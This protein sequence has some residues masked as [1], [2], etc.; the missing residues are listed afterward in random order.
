MLIIHSV[1]RFWSDVLLIPAYASALSISILF[2]QCITKLVKKRRLKS[3]LQEPLANGNT[4]SPEA[5]L[6]RKS[7]LRKHI[8]ELGGLAIFGWRLARLLACVA[9]LA[10]SVYTVRL[11][12]QQDSGASESKYYQWFQIGLSAVYAYTLL[13]ALGSVL[14]NASLSR[15]VVRHLALVLV[16]VWAVFC[17]RDLW[18]LA[19]YTLKPLDA[20]EGWLIWTKIGLLTFA[21]AAVPLLVPRQY[22]PVDPSDPA[23]QPNV[24]QTACI[25]SMMLYNF[26]DPVIFLGYRTPH[27]S[28]EQLPPLS[29]Y[30]Y[31]KNVVKRGFPNLDPFVTKS[32]RHLFFGLMKTFRSEYMILSLMIVL[33]VIS[34]FAVP[35]GIYRLLNYLTDEGGEDIVR[36]WVWIAWL[37]LGPVLGAI[38]VQWY[39]FV[40]TRMLVQSQALITQ[41]VFNHALRVRVKA[42]A[43]TSPTP[44]TASSV[45]TTPDTDSVTGE[46]DSPDSSSSDSEDETAASETTSTTRV[47]RGLSSHPESVSGD[48]DTAESTGGGNFVGKLNNLITTDLNNLTDGRDFLF[49]VLYI[50]FQVGLCVWFLYAILG[51]SALVGMVVII[52]MFPLP[53]YIAKVIQNVQVERMKKT[54]ARVQTVT[55]IMN[56]IRMIKIFGW[57]PKILEQLAEKREAELKFLRQFKLLDLSNGLLNFTIPVLTMIF[58]FMTY[59]LVMKQELTASRVFS[60]MSPKFLCDR[61]NDF[62]LNTELLDKYQAEVNDKSSAARE[63]VA[64]QDVDPSVIGIREAAFTWSSEAD[65]AQSPGEHHRNFTLRIDNEV[66]FKN[67]ALNL[68]VGP[69]GSGKTSFLMA[70]L[71][72]MHYLPSGPNSYVQLPRDGGVAYAAQESWVQN[73]TI[74]DNILFGAP[75]DQERYDKVIDQCGLKRDLELFE[76]GDKTEVGEKGLTLS[77]GQKARITL[78]RAIYSSAKILLLDDVLAA[79][80]VHTAKWVVDKCFKGD[81]IQGRTVLLVTHNVHMVKPIAEFVVS[82]G[83]D[84]KI[85]SQGSLSKALS[86]NKKLAQ[87]VKRVAEAHKAQLAQTQLEQTT[88]RTKKSDGK[89]IVAEE[90]SVGHVGWPAL[91]LYFA[92]LGGKMPISFWVLFLGGMLLTSITETYQAWYL[93]HWADQYETHDPSEVNVVYYIIVYTLLLLVLLISYLVACFVFVYGCLR[94]SRA[95]HAHLVSSVLGTT[96]RWLDRTPTSRIITRCTQDIQ[97]VDG[98]I[99]MYLGYLAEM[100]SSMLLKFIGVIVISPQFIIPGIIVSILGGWCGQIY[101]KSQLAVKRE[102][103][104]NRAPVLGHVGAAMGGLASIRAYGAEQAFTLESY[105]RIDRYS[106]PARTFYN[107]NRWVCIR[108]ETLA[109]LF[110]ASLGAYLVYWGG[111]S[112]SNTGF[113]LTMAVGFS[114]MI[115]W[116]I[117]LLNDFEVSG[118]SLERIQQYVVIEQEPKPTKHGVPPAYWPTSGELIVENLSAK[119][120][121]EGANVLQDVSFHVK[122]GERVGIVGR[123]GSGKSSLSLALLRCILTQGMILYDGM[124]T[125]TLNLD[126]LRSNITIIPQ[127][128]ELL[129]GTL[130]QNLDPFSQH[131][132]ATLNDALHA[133]G[134]YSLQSETDDTRLTLDSPIASGGG[135][136]SVG[137]RQILALARAIV[138]RSKLLILDEDYETD[139]IIQTSLRQQLDKDVTLLTIA[140]RLQTIMDADKIMV[141]DAGRLVEFDKPSELL[142]KENG[143]LRALVDE[144]EDRDRLM[145]M[146]TGAA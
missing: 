62:L 3:T 105:R 14:C 59:T 117:R 37:L 6:S 11:G 8:D 2:L 82:L 16:T 1:I 54:D 106:R 118:N 144:S 66:K 90:I 34:T 36:P 33:R 115:L 39:I 108:I 18:P 55:E 69:T 50:P 92:N 53:G 129:S 127:V 13:L 38:A 74:R 63:V 19:T 114:G 48:Q 137:Q 30:D 121:A 143:M 32:R 140:H 138:R 113:S 134:L 72:E 20:A 109:G 71:G 15:I 87:K 22:I 26:L 29:D 126:A 47:S 73:E 10:L 43:T 60:S 41:L 4:S 49:V 122:A 76:A 61:V 111:V 110:A 101:M 46:S 125:D 23:P 135:N 52:L 83:T 89:L 84:G 24:E 70:L 81:L 7:S 145:A 146:A 97:A 96:L 88:T 128:P 107:L 116:W 40:A 98:P 93:G 5:Q 99:A 12:P 136:L 123:T 119:Y 56:V 86:K 35:I 102:M 132:D 65:G 139:T 78:A 51:W 64:G 142:K 103:S 124:P 120:S 67:G 31:T 58:T 27:L 85:K 79:L 112:A 68:I 131:D 80:D 75:F 94:A 42:E 133:A 95:I 28:W 130:R 100:T 141:L 44:S 104:N 57:E 17:Y 77:G 91:K 21:G 9:L 45:A 25:L